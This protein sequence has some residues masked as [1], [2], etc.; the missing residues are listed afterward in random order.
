MEAASVSPKPLCLTVPRVAFT[1]PLPSPTA[2]PLPNPALATTPRAPREPP[3]PLPYPGPV[4]KSKDPCCAMVTGRPLFS[5]AGTPFGSPNPPVC[6]C[7]GARAMVGVAELPVEKTL[8]FTNCRGI[9]GAGC[10]ATGLFAATSIL[11]GAG[12]SS[13]WTF[14]LIS[15]GR[16]RTACDGICTTAGGLNNRTG[17]G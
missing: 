11:G 7:S 1:V 16:R 8:V 6:T 10:R 12:G 2:T 15:G 14:A 17:W 3:V 4:G 5:R 13:G 9:T